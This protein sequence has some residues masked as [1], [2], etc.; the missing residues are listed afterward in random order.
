[1]L[2]RRDGIRTR[3]GGEDGELYFEDIN[4]AVISEMEK[5]CEKDFFDL[6][7]GIQDELKNRKEFA[8]EFLQ[9][10]PDQQEFADDIAY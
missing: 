5:M 6:I 3:V 9:R 7:P 4:E 1:M 8:A 10:H 2:S